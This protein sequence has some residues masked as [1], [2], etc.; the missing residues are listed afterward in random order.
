MPS[1]AARHSWWRA[2]ARGAL[3]PWLQVA[4]V[5][6]NLFPCWGASPVDTAVS[7]HPETPAGDL[8]GIRV[9]R[10]DLHSTVSVTV[11][12]CDARRNSEIS[13][14]AL[15]DG[16]TMTTGMLQPLPKG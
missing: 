12:E 1:S 3:F 9:L 5:H 7:H 14:E 2:H 4:H 8:S 10:T 13:G 11:E 15:H 6:L 16:L